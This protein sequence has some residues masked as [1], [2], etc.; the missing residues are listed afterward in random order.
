MQLVNS[1]SDALPVDPFDPNYLD[2]YHQ[3]RMYAGTLAQHECLVDEVD[4]KFFTQWLW[5]P[6]IDKTGKKYFRRAVNVWSEGIKLATNT[7]YLHIEILTRAEGPP[8]TER[9]CIA[10]HW[11]GDSL[12]NRRQNLRWVTQRQNKR[13]RFGR[14]FYQR[15]LRGV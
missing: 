14:N 15:E 7:V 13:N 9:R 4:Y 3:F 2:F 11:N 8:P 1:Q 5:V 10:D 12:D 6:K